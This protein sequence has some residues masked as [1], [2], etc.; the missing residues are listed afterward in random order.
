MT[1][2]EAI[3]RL[4]DMIIETRTYCDESKHMNETD[5]Q[6]MEALDMAIK[7]LEQERS[8]SAEITQY[9]YDCEKLMEENER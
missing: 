5:K 9:R 1:L 2:E 3:N 7:A 6:N 8:R 4:R